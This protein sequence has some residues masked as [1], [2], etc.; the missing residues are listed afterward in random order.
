M[1]LG[2]AVAKVA[3]PIA[4]V[5]NMDCIDPKTQQVRPDSPCNQHKVALNDFGDA[6]FDFFWQP[7]NKTKDNE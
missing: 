6:V 3:T 2:D 4:R 1:K 5:L 7:K